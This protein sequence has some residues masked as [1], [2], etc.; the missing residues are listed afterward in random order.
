MRMELVRFTTTKLPESQ[1]L[2]V[3]FA[4]PTFNGERTL[5]KCLASIRAQ[6]YPNVEIV[7]VDGYSQDKTLEIAR[8]FTD[9]VYMCNGP[10]GRCRQLSV[11][12]STGHIIALFDAD[13]ILPHPK[14]L[15]NAVMQ[16]LTSDKNVASME[17]LY[18]PV[19]GASLLSRLYLLHS[20]RVIKER[21]I[22]GK[23]SLGGGNS[24][25]LRTRIMEAG[26]NEHAPSTEDLDLAY[27]L[28][29]K[30]YS[31]IIAHEPI[32]HDTHVTLHEIVRKEI[33]RAKEFRSH[34]IRKLIG[35]TTNELLYEQLAFGLRGMILGLLKDKEPAWALFPIYLTIRIMVYG[36]VFLSTLVRGKAK[37]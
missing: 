6:K 23:G 35:L 14:W 30:G 20:N 11:E 15:Y 18:L 3:S 5:Q 9:G 34:G 7:I 33:V 19:T 1:L 12:K 17:I 8:C 25:F 22:R 31:V 10:L 36:A 16:F 28:R 27:K 24:L 21:A 26:I 2:L 32:F 29:S 37:T 13:I 4:I